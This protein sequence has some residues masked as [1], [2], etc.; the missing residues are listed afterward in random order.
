MLKYDGVTADGDDAIGRACLL[1]RAG[2]IL[3]LK[4]LGGWQLA[5]DARDEAA[6]MRLR[7][8]KLRPHKPFAVMTLDPE[9]LVVLDGT[10]LAAL[11]EPAQPIILAP[12]RNE[13]APSVA[14]RLRELGLM[15]PTTPLHHL[16]ML[17]GPPALVMT[18]GN[19]SEEP[20]AIDD[21][22]ALVTLAP[23]ADAFLLHNREIHTRADDSVGRVVRGKMQPVRRG[24]GWAPAPIALSIEAKD[25]PSVLAVGAEVKNAVCLTR[26]DEAFLSQHIGDLSGPKARA[27]FEESI[28]K[29]ERL[30]GVTPAVVAHDLHPDYAATRWAKTSGLPLIAVQHHHAHVASCLA[31]HGLG[32]PAIGVA[33][34]GTGCGPAGD[35]WG[36]E[37]L[38]FDLDGFSRAF[39]LRPIALPGGEAAIREPWRLGVA[40][41]ADA[42]ESLEL[43]RFIDAAKIL[44]IL[45]KRGLSPRA[46]GAGRWFDAVAAIVGVRDAISY[47]A[48][49]AIELEAVADNTCDVP[50][51]FTFEN[52]EIDLRPTIRALLR[53]PAPIAAARF[54][55]T[56][57]EAVR[58]ACLEIRRDL[59][60]DMVALS[61][62]CFQNAM[63]TE[64]T[65]KR[66]ECEG[67]RVL[68]H[69]RVPPNDGGLALGQAAIAAHRLEKEG[70]D[71]SRNPW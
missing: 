10:A 50:Y 14:P 7:E 12:S 8:R 11:H 51:P 2:R 28:A 23:I 18:S 57:A 1:L 20:I 68:V 45:G 53:D 43:E 26:G 40:A 52:G 9:A 48:Q 42:G 27:F 6:V 3:A 30:L 21:D 5:C 46:S 58:S 71:V 35:A 69:R 31:E 65:A 44:P 17:D 32:G 67:F 49:A 39:H 38:T 64:R 62:G 66:L 25:G 16:L 63:L 59:G 4:G 60:L 54:H 34:D 55:S 24:R 47:E 56:L 36:G 41:L 61:G 37:I 29:L 33:F 70:R 22:D 13:V 15:L 19:M